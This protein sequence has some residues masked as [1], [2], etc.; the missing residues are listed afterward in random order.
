MERFGFC[1]TFVPGQ[2]CSFSSDR[3]DLDLAFIH[4][5]LEPREPLEARR[6]FPGR[7][8]T[9]F[10]RR[11]MA[12]ALEL[13]TKGAPVQEAGHVRA[14]SGHP[15]HL[16]S[17]PH[18]VALDGPGGEPERLPFR[19]LLKPHDGHPLAAIW[20]NQGTVVCSR[21]WAPD[22]SLDS[23]RQKAGPSSDS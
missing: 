8:A 23:Q 6:I 13:I 16:V 19:E 12:R 21:G 14:C 5:D 11:A 2:G 4:S 22:Q 18:E 3:K 15:R 17:F 7:L 9:L 1:R 10:E 20:G